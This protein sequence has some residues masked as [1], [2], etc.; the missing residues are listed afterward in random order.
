[1]TANQAFLS[2]PEVFNNAFP[3][4]LQADVRLWT[5]NYSSLLPLLKWYSR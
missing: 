5:D 4:H 3:T 1:V 2:Q